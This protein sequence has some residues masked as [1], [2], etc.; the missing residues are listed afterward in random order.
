MLGDF[1]RNCQTPTGLMPGPGSTASWLTEVTPPESKSAWS[2]HS[3]F[4]GFREPF[5]LHFRIGSGTREG[6]SMTL[7]PATSKP[8]FARPSRSTSPETRRVPGQ[9]CGERCRAAAAGRGSCVR[10]HF[11]AGSFL[12][13]PRAPALS[14]PSTSRP[15]PKRPGTPIGR[16]KLLEEIGEGGMGVV[17]MAEQQRAG[18]PQGGPE[19]HQAGHGHRGRSIAR[20]EAE[21]QAL[22]LMDHPNIA[23]VLDAG[24]HR[25]RAGRTS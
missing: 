4:S 8:F 22:A 21:R 23:K 9:A 16:Y 12:E 13:M 11:A 17:Y 6:D 14:P 25:D 10:N 3:V 19:D 7:A 1:T 5:R 24:T 20:F 15:P 18:P 2:Q